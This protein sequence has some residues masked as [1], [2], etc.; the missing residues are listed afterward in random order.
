MKK[1][2]K[3]MRGA[4]KKVRLVFLVYTRVS[5]F[6]LIL[7]RSLPVSANILSHAH[8]VQC[9]RKTSCC[10]CR[11]VCLYLFFHRIEIKT[12]SSGRFALH[13]SLFRRRFRCR[14]LPRGSHS[15]S[16]LSLL[17]AVRTSSTRIRFY[18]ATTLIRDAAT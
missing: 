4:W 18:T 15:Y 12:R 8:V 11:C 13:D 3:K 2:K 7:S 14:S 1:K 10:I 5:S 6:S 9:L 17:L 16:Q